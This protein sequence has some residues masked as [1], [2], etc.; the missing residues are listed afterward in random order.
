MADDAPRRK[1]IPPLVWIIVGLLVL[2]VAIYFVTK[3]GEVKTPDT[4]VSMPVDLPDAPT[5]PEP[6]PPAPP[7]P[8]PR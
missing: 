7:L 3:D 6:N 4:G 1:G 5:M 8:A 2:L